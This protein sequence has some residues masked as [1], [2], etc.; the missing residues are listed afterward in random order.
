MLK[1]KILIMDTLRKRKLV[2]DTFAC[3]VVS[4]WSQWSTFFTCH[5]VEHL[6][7]HNQKPAPRPR[8]TR[9]CEI[10]VDGVAVKEDALEIIDRMGLLQ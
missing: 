5:F 3:C 2:G 1:N 7:E 10:M 4:G 9:V 8:K 6:L